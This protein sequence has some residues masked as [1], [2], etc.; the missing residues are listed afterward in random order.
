MN[1][2]KKIPLLIASAVMIVLVAAV[3]LIIRAVNK[4]IDEVKSSITATTEEE[5]IISTPEETI[6]ECSEESSR[7]I[8]TEVITTEEVTTTTES[9]TETVEWSLAVDDLSDEEQINSYTIKKVTP[10][11][12]KIKKDGNGGNIRENCFKDAKI[13]KYEDGGE[14]VYTVIEEL[15]NPLNEVWWYYI[16]WQKAGVD[17]PGCGYIR[18]TRIEKYVPEVQTSKVEV[19]STSVINFDN[20]KFN[21]LVELNDFVWENRAQLKNDFVGKRKRTQKFTT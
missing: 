4:R 19:E 7:E 15:Y 16:T 6:E 3:A 8:T 21:R 11:E 1:N 14:D 17:D 18:N 9:N 12:V 2:S 10:Y 20:L 5:I 13:V